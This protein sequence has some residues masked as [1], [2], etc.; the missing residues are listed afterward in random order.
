MWGSFVCSGDNIDFDS[1]NATKSMD[2]AFAP[3][4]EAKIPWAAILG[5]HDHESSLSRQDVMSYLT[6]MDYSLSKILDPSMESLLGKAPSQTP[7]EVNGV[8]NYYLQ[9]FGPA[10]SDFE[11]SSALNLYFLDT[12][13]YSKFAHVDGY[14]WIRANQLL[15]YQLLAAKLRVRRGG[16]LNFQIG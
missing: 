16:I 1:T 8:G 10:G 5:N 3:V 2:D 15:W 11:N 7:I 14:D 13:E 4:I 6:K 12:G 9:V